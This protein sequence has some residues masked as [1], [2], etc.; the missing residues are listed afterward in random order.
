MTQVTDKVFD[1][2]SPTDNSA[3]EAK[4]MDKKNVDVAEKP[5]TLVTNEQ[6]NKT[7]EQHLQVDEEVSD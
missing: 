2:V 6:A 7:E 3:N 4:T 5:S 1:I